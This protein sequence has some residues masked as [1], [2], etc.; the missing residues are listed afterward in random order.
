[1]KEK[2]MNYLNFLELIQAYHKKSYILFYEYVKEN[3]QVQPEEVE[4]DNKK[5]L[6]FLAIKK[7]VD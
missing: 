3:Y 7:M 1:M 6:L 5:F 2:V 4:L